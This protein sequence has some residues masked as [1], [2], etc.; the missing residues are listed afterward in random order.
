MK[1]LSYATILNRAIHDCK[2]SLESYKQSA[3]EYEQ[4]F[5][6]VEAECFLHFAK[7]AEEELEALLLLYEVETGRKYEEE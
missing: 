5:L 6:A 1:R 3:E 7:S 2:N 4:L